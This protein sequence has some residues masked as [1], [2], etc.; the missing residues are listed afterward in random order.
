MTKI[1]ELI[2]LAKK[3]NKHTKDELEGKLIELK[4]LNYMK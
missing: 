3:E 2:E 1:E 4:L